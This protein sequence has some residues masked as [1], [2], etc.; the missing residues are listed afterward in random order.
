MKDLVSKITVFFQGCRLSNGRYYSVDVVILKRA[1]VQDVVGL[2]MYM[3]TEAQKKPDLR[4]STA[5]VS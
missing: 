5:T 3:Y 4:V 1:S 2:A